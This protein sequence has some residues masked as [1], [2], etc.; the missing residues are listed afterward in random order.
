MECKEKANLKS[1]NCSSEGC[2]R[3]GLC[4]E[5]L[6]H[7]RSKG[8]L[9]ACYFPDDVEKTHN[10]SADIFIKTVQERGICW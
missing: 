2:S 4:C 3:K 5:C 6:T 1:C 7:H 8:Q 10:R 9:P